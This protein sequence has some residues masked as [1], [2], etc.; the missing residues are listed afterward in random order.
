MSLVDLDALLAPISDDAPCGPDLRGDPAFREIE[1]APGEFASMKAPELLKQVRACIDMLKRSKDQ[2]PAIVGVQAALRA[3]DLGS[4]NA[5]LQFIARTADDHWDNFH[6]G[7]AEEMAIGRVNEL[8]A[9]SRPAAALLPLQRLGVARMPAPSTAEFNAVVLAM[10]LEPVPEWGYEDDE[11]LKSQTESGAIT[12]AA[13]R[14]A[15]PNREAARQLRG[16]MVSLSDDERARDSAAGTLVSDKDAGP[17]RPLA[18]ALRAG[19]AATRA[20]LAA[21]ADSLYTIVDVFD[22]RMNDS[23]GFGPIQSQLRAMIEPCD[24]FLEMFPDPDAVVAVAD[25]GDNEAAGEAAGEAGADGSSG[26]KVAAPKRF[27]G[28]IPQSRADVLVGIDALIKYYRDVEPTSPVPIMLAR[29]R[30]WVE[31]DFYQILKEIAPDSVSEVRRLL[32]IRED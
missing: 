22:R 3:G 15:R 27:S 21:L 19:V 2:M 25:A 8:S 5:L 4:A 20:D 24:K 9:L 29:V 26:A 7:P 10:A 1:D 23:P 30:G 6:P 32:A 16:I 13:A 12:A 17:P 14:A 28:D 11:K 31:Q 18:A